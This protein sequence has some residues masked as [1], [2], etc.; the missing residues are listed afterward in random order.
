[1]KIAAVS[2]SEGSRVAT[3]SPRSTPRE[4]SRFANW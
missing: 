2:G 4:R 1:M 3:L